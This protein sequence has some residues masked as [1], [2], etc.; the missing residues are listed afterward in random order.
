MVEVHIMESNYVVQSNVFRCDGIDTF[1]EPHP[2]CITD[3][4]V[5]YASDHHGGMLDER[6]I[7]HAEKHGAKC[8]TKGCYL[9]H[10]E[11][12]SQ[13]VLVIVLPNDASS[14]LNTIPELKEWL[15]SIKQQL[16]DDGVK[17]IIFPSER[18]RRS[19]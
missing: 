13:K 12:I 17:G 8:G 5:A 6:A 18:Q 11:H 4:H 7:E 10:K 3:K 19:R 15:F 1:T 9:K 16:I 14:D 2:Y